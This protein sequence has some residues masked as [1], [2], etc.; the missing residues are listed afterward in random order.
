MSAKGPLKIVIALV[1]FL[2]FT[3]IILA[4]GL[5]IF[6]SGM[7]APVFYQV[8]SMMAREEDPFGGKIDIRNARLSSWRLRSGLKAIAGFEEFNSARAIHV[9]TVTT[10]RD[11]LKPGE[12]LPS[13]DSHDLYVRSRVGFIAKEECKRLLELLAR[14]CEFSNTNANRWRGNLYNVSFTLRFIQNDAFG[15]INSEATLN[16]TEI[17]DEFSNRLR[18]ARRWNDKYLAKF[19]VKAYKK[20]NKDCKSIKKDHGN[21]ALLNAVFQLRAMDINNGPVMVT[22]ATFS[23]LQKL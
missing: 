9:A 6:G 12:E 5:Q 14:A 18:N 3:P 10:L 17:D 15:E 20:F 23:V 1:L 4:L 22:N 16:Y 21:C 11:L 2:F 19:R 8:S 7:M 13:K